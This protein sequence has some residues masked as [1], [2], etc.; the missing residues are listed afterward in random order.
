MPH[1]TSA[2]EFVRRALRAVV[3]ASTFR[4]VSANADRVEAFKKL[5]LRE[6]RQ[7]MNALA[8]AN[9]RTSHMLTLHPTTLAHPFQLRPIESDARSFLGTCIRSEYAPVLPRKAP[10]Y[11]ID[12]GAFTGDCSALILTRYPGAHLVALEPQADVFPLTR[13]NLAPYG[14]VVRNLALWSANGALACDGAGMGMTVSDR[15]GSLSVSCSSMDRVL[16]EAAFPRIDLFKCDIEGAETAVFSGDRLDWL[17][18]TTCV[19][20]ELHGAEASQRVHAAC[21][22]A[23]LRFVTQYRSTHVFRR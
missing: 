8:C 22:D 2:G 10:E 4:S 17:Q 15:H 18:R 14:A 3:P 1:P 5:P 19:L 23:G 9:D 16:A 20:I 6:A 21:R 13:S 11:V 12:A 7:L